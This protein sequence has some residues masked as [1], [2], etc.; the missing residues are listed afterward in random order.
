MICLMEMSFMEVVK[1]Q[2]SIAISNLEKAPLNNGVA[3]TTNKKSDINN[4]PIILSIS[5]NNDWV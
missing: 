3:K 1:L 2:E 5:D 4:H